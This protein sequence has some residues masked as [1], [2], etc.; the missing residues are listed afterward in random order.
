MTLSFQTINMYCIISKL[1]AKYMEH[2]Q[3]DSNSFTGLNKHFFPYE[4]MIEFL[5]YGSN[6]YPACVLWQLH[7]LLLW[8]TVF[9]HLD[10]FC[11]YIMEICD[12]I[13][14]FHCVLFNVTQYVCE[15]TWAEKDRW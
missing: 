9:G 6:C 2:F 10:V 12:L 3:A 15:E 7:A 8:V 11:S 14:S 13:C 5:T 1:D 4:K